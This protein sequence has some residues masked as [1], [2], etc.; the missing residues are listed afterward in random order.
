[1]SIRPTSQ[2]DVEL[3]YLTSRNQRADPFSGRAV[4]VYCWP[5]LG[6]HSI[7]LPWVQFVAL[8]LVPTTFPS[9]SLHEPQV[10]INA[11]CLTV[12]VRSRGGQNARYGQSPFDITHIGAAGRRLMT[13]INTLTPTNCPRPHRQQLV[14]R[15]NRPVCYVRRPARQ[16]AAGCQLPSCLRR[17]S[18]EL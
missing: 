8:Y 2:W 4:A 3:G 9:P 17:Q 13:I 7:C 18:G 10:V 14:T 1:M 6:N 5:L 11:R 15:G 12:C 16:R